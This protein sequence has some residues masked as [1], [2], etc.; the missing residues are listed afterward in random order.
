MGTGVMCVGRSSRLAAVALVVL[1]SGCSLFSKKDARAC[2]HVEIVSDLSRVVK[3]GNG[4]GRDLSDVVYSARIDDVKSNCTYDGTGVTVEMTVSLLGER[5]RA[6]LALPT[7]DVSYFVAIIDRA[8]NIIA[9]RVFTSTFTFPDKGLASINDEFVQR[10][11]LAPTA[12]GSDHT[13]ILG[14]Q[15]SREEI[16][17]NDKNRG[18]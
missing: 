10:I 1:L 8:Q 9:K 3:F 16:D 6:G 17:F 7:S 2:P 14:F 11:P 13:V 4:P 12:P 5:G 18:S 15:L